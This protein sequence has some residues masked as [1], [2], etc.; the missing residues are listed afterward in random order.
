M[1]GF[2]VLCFA[3]YSF[4][5]RHGDESV[6]VNRPARPVQSTPAPVSGSGSNS[7]SSNSG[8]TAGSARPYKDG[9]YTGS[10]ADAFY[11]YVQVLAVISSGRLTE[12][13]FL[14]YPNDRSTSV[15]INSQA[16]P[17]LQQEAI[18]AQS[19]HVDIIS[20]ATDTS[21]AFIQ[22]LSAALSK[23]AG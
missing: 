21:Q 5:Q 3:A 12:V 13:R 1:S 19:A 2:V 6:A 15:E 18:Q 14:Q 7:G 8:G 11:G 4:H 10:T 20:G 23:A 9:Q 22:S 16:I 17:Y